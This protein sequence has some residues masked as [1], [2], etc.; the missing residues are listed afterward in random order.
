[1]VKPT[2]YFSRPSLVVAPLHPMVE[3]RNEEFKYRGVRKRKWGKYVSEIRIPNS[4]ERI[5]LG[6][7]DTAEKAARSFDAAQFC[8]RGH[9][10]VFNFP[11][12]PPNIIGGQSLSPAEIQV[13]VAQYANNNQHETD[14]DFSSI[15]TQYETKVELEDTSSSSNSDGAVAPM[16]S[17]DWSFLDKLDSNAVENISDFCLFSSLDNFPHNIYMQPNFAHDDNDNDDD[18]YA[19]SE[20]HFSEQSFLWNFQT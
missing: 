7:Y 12:D 5:W 2:Q 10:A 4:R 18:D 8:L 3:N 6:S 9:N 19:I 11:H 15:E 13:V 16:E 14:R 1:M 17:M 20:G